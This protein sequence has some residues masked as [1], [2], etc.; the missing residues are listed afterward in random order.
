MPFIMYNDSRNVRIGNPAIA[1]EM[2][3]IAEVN[4]LLPFM[5]GK[6][7]WLTSVYGRFTE[8][9]ITSYATPLP[10][11]TSILLNTFV[12]GS[13]EIRGGWENI[14]KIEPLKGLQFTISTELEYTDVGLNEAEG[15]ARNQGM[16]WEV[17][18]LISYR[19]LKDWA[20]Q[21]N[22]EYESP[23]ITAQGRR[24][25]QYYMDAS[26]SHDFTKRLTGVLSVN[27]VFYTNR[28]GSI[29]DTPMLYQENYRRREQRFVR[30]TLTWRFGEQN[31]LFRRDRNRPQRDPGGSN[32]EIGR[33]SC[34]G[35]G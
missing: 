2:S 5:K 11:D 7:T 13:H 24:V 19:F 18:G 10:S 31:S 15:G 17:K 8:D 32:G 22:G 4:H 1:P 26:L 3:N 29:I 21:L 30:F 28:W 14:V 25:E 27:D 23:E 33:A 34:R 12:N 35:R 6:A 20:L 9:A 16:A